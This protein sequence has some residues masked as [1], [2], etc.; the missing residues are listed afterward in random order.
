MDSNVEAKTIFEVH[1]SHFFIEYPHHEH[2]LVSDET[3]SYETDE[4]DCQP[5]CPNTENDEGATPAPEEA[6]LERFLRVTTDHE[7]KSTSVGFMFGSDKDVCDILV[8]TEWQGGISKKHFALQIEMPSGHGTLIFKSHTR[9]GTRVSSAEMPRKLVQTQRAISENDRELSVFISGLKIQL[10]FPDHRAHEAEW[11]QNWSEYCRRYSSQVPV[12]NHL[13]IK[14]ASTVTSIPWEGRYHLGAELGAGAFG[15]VR[16]VTDARTGQRYA[17]KQYRTLDCRKEIDLPFLKSLSHES[18]IKFHEVCLNPP[19]LIM[20]LVDG[21]NLED[22]HQETAV[23]GI[24]LRNVTWLLADA[25]TYLHDNRIIHRDLKPSNIMVSARHPIRIKLVDFGV[26]TDTESSV[27]TSC[28]GSP[29]YWAPEIAGGRYTDKVDV[30]S[31]GVISL[32][33]SGGLPTNRKKER[34]QRTLA[35]HVTGLNSE[36]TFREDSVEAFTYS[37]LQFDPDHRPTA[38]RCRDM[39]F[40]LSPYIPTENDAC[41]PPPRRYTSGL[42]LAV[43]HYVPS[44]ESG[45]S[46]VPNTEYE[47]GSTIRNATP[48]GGST[49]RPT[50]LSIQH[51]PI[52]DSEAEPA[53]TLTGTSSRKRPASSEYSIVRQPGVS[54]TAS[55]PL[56]APTPKCDWS[57]GGIEDTG[58]GFSGAASPSGAPSLISNHSL[59]TL[60]PY[61]TSMPYQTPK[62][63]LSYQEWQR[64]KDENEKKAGLRSVEV[65]DED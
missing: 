33:L 39:P 61:S 13:T 44:G 54:R 42:R 43:Q 1:S 8:A 26:A 28:A 22:S 35:N 7:P 60:P 10:L 62:G 47:G 41:T 15:T 21:I 5:V 38:A 63:S 31:L 24:E 55:G 46:T 19:S 36:E 11:Q 32:E 57:Y 59:S 50:D 34:W 17:A 52:E 51:T 16:L 64:E 4:W 9:H 58:Y 29:R 2:L 3:P 40:T 30:W 53:S 49:L 23:K 18:I 20:E 27:K 45:E 56:F 48:G 65:E 6:P 25:L 12:L 14:S 37:L